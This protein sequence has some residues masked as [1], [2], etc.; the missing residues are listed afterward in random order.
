MG[1]VGIVGREAGQEG[2]MQGDQC[3]GV[4]SRGV[5]LLRRTGTWKRV[6]AQRVN[7][8]WEVHWWLLG[9]LSTGGPWGLSSLSLVQD[10]S[11]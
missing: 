3:H 9:S 4:G 1:G 7:T 5:A 6:S 11:S 10:V 2:L 8:W